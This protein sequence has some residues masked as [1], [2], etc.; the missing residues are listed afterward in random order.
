GVAQKIHNWDWQLELAQPAILDAP[1]DAVSSISAQGQMGLG[2]TYYASNTNSYPAAAFL[3][4]GF[5]RFDGERSNLRVGR[6]EYIDGQET[7]PKDASISWLQ[8]NRIA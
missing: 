1:D 7:S 3:K 2:G 8:T 4:Q 5:A 6:F